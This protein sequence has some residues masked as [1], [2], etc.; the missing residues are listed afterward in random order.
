[1]RLVSWNVNGIRAALKKGFLDFAGDTGADVICLQETRAEPEQAEFELAGYRQF[2]NPAEKKGYSGTMMLSRVEPLGVRLGIGM[3]KHEGEGRVITLE[4]P[5]YFLT[6]VYTP[7]AQRELTRLDYRLEWD[8]DFLKFL[9]K[10][11]KE[12]PVVF[13]G[14]LNVAH[15]EIDLANPK[16]NMK[17]A[18]FTPEEREGFDR[19]VQ[20]GFVDTFR[21]FCPDPGRYT[22]W[23]QMGGARARN[24]G[25]RI[26]YFCVSGAL[27]S[28]L[29]SATIQPEVMG[30]DH[31]PVLLELE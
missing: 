16:S 28:R 24:I 13:C 14:D 25:W 15:R 29:G 5:E 27:G 19:I 22:W 2:W 23:S 11:E 26:D 9:K 3:K 30:S 10:L 21:A 4:F 12:K 31:C 7:N 8:R 17:N 18:G 20:A 6:N 1:M